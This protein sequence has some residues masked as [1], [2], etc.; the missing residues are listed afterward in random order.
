MVSNELRISFTAGTESWL[1]KVK[2]VRQKPTQN[3]I[4]NLFFELG[5]HG[6]SWSEEQSAFIRRAAA[7][8]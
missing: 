1:L 7:Q 5:D 2:I 4:A 8:A 6:V 3:S